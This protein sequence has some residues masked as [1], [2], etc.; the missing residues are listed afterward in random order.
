MAKQISNMPHDPSD[1]NG[2]E[3]REIH[4]QRLALIRTYN[5]W[6]AIGCAIAFSSYWFILYLSLTMASRPMLI[7]AAL[8]ASVIIWFSYRAVL[9]IDREV[10]SLYPRI[11]FLELALGYDFYRDYLRG[12]PR[13]NSERSYIE[14]CEQL[15]AEDSR[16]LWKK[17]YSLYNQSDFPAGRRLSAH[18]KKATYLSVILFWIIIALIL[19]PQYFPLAK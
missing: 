8:V 11:I 6:F 2:T 1:S 13:G 14:R 18:F 3:Y 12:R 19:A 4:K 17:I 5:M 16:L 9:S 10:V 15:D 7:A